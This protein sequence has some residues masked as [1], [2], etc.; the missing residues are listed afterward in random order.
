MGQLSFDNLLIA[1][2]LADDDAVDVTELRRIVLEI[3]ADG[4]EL[5]ELLA[6]EGILAANS[7]A[8]KSASSKAKSYLGLMR[9]STW[10]EVLSR[11]TRVPQ[12]ALKRMQRYQKKDKHGR[13]LGDLLKQAG[14]LD[15][16][17]LERYTKRVMDRLEFH[18]DALIKRYRKAE[19]AGLARKVSTNKSGP[20]K[21]SS[22]KA[23]QSK[24]PTESS[25]EVP[26]TRRS[27]TADNLQATFEKLPGGERAP[28]M[29]AAGEGTAKFD[30][31]Q[32]AKPGPESYGGLV[33]QD[34]FEL[35]KPIGQGA[36]GVV[37]LA[38]DRSSGLE[39]AVK[40][41]LDPE[42]N[43]DAK[44]RFERETMVS[45][46]LDHHNLVKILGSGSTP[47]GSLYLAMELVKGEELEDIVKRE[48][49]LP[50]G[51]CFDLFEQ[52][53]EGMKA[54]HDAQV[55]HRDL[56]PENILVARNGESDTIKIMD[57]GLARM[58]NHADREAESGGE[59]FMTMAGTVTGT[60]AYLAPE[61]INGD[62]IGPYT[63]LY[64]LGVSLFQMLTKAF[65]YKGKSVNALLKAH[66][67]KSP[68]QLTEVCEGVP[69][70]PEMQELIEWLLEKSFKKRAGDCGEVLTFIREKIRPK[71]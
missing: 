40:L 71:I 18:K 19:F 48:G 26:A 51:R 17:T 62:Q 64:S 16:P 7:E 56:K 46:E 61:S 63:D 22:V 29:P 50:F 55:V 38:K 30:R 11:S 21:A 65:P 12:D 15:Q 27:E 54:V 10:G 25:G 42:S 59:I 43:P 28:A 23:A 44:A 9:E 36:M 8:Y 6:L 2:M 33:L 60:P 68:R 49:P 41:I 35:V 3:D 32:L 4:G 58:L 37:Y 57:F 39:A 24:P 66:L 13:S 69:Y 67:Y 20:V 5:S 31:G 52:I 53:L 14:Y 70:I 47:D 34:R 1:K 45:S